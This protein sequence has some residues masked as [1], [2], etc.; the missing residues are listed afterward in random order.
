MICWKINKIQK[1][2]KC[3]FSTFLKFLKIQDKTVLFGLR[4]NK[5]ERIC[6]WLINNYYKVD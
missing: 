5:H 6:R 4:E 3:N 1:N 2:K